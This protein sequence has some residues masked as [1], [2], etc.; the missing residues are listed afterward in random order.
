MQ[1]PPFS[2]PS[3][4]VSYAEDRQTRAEGFA[5]QLSDYEVSTICD[6]ACFSID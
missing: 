6:T 5:K 3:P 1:K 4:P 2:L